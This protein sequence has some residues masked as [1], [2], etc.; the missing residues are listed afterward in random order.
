MEI[1][2]LI[3]FVHAAQHGSFSAT[4]K[5]LG[6]SQAAITIQIQKLEEELQAQLFDRFSRKIQLT[7]SG[8][9]FY[10]HAL[11]ILN[12][13]SEAKA[14]L[15]NDVEIKGTLT[16]GTTD[17]VCSTIF[18]E[19][20]EKYHT[21][22]PNVK[23]TI[24]TESILQL[25]EMLKKNEIDFAYLIDQ[26]WTGPQWNKIINTKEPVYFITSQFIID[27]LDIPCDISDILRFPLL[28]TE[29]DASYRQILDIQ[30]NQ[31]HMQAQPIIES[32]NTDLLIKCIQKNMG[33]TF[34]PAFITTNQDIQIIP[35]KNFSLEVYRQVIVHNDKWISL[36]MRTFFDYLL[37]IQ[38]AN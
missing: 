20:I 27:Q 19:L 32:K 2:Q 33:I 7:N 11:K 31:N 12:D 9:Q 35:V 4:A 6:Y 10:T 30:L 15:Y 38:N 37:H 13:I 24:I 8:K 28:L 29:K 23:I 34:L 16:I 21:L 17:S 18:P 5:Q 25:E 3:T 36:E 1:Q 14:S 22:Y 26:E